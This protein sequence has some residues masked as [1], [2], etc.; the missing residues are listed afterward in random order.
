VP[1]EQAGIDT[2]KR[3]VF[4]CGSATTMPVADKTRLRPSLKAS[5]R[6]KTSFEISQA[7]L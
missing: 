7:L 4:V 2:K 5:F 6:I 3:N 1:Y